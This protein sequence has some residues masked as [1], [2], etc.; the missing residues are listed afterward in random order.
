MPALYRPQSVHSVDDLRDW[1]HY[2][3]LAFSAT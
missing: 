2:L 3:P 1:T